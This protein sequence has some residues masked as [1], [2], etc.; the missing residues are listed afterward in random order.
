MRIP[1]IAGNWKMNTTIGEAVKL[2][3]EM[4][5]G[6]DKADNVDNSI[7]IDE[8]GISLFSRE[9][10][11]QSNKI[12]AKTFM[13]QRFLNV[14]V[15]ICIPHFWSL[16]TLVRNHR[17]NTLIIITKRGKYKAIV[18]Q[19]IKILNKLG[20]K[21]TTKPLQALPIPYKYFWEGDF[22]KDF[23]KNID[24][25]IYDKHKFKHIQDFLAE[26]SAEAKS[27]KM[28]SFKQLEKDFGLTKEDMMMEQEAGRIKCRKIGKNWFID[29]KDYKKLFFG[30]QTN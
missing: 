1:M 5:A 20:K 6:L 22:Y 29:K 10:L 18:G 13:V 14:H 24:N 17:I 3:S 16:D 25:A 15:C 30:K 9:S 4:R 8:G 2:V 27:M 23:P 28:Y 7:L 11:T 26:V 21:D 19:G 12:L